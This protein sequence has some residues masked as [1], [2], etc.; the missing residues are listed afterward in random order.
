M[1]TKRIPPVIGLAG[2]GLVL[3]A[4]WIGAAIAQGRPDF[5]GTWVYNAAKSKLEVRFKL[6]SAVF[7]IDHKE[8]RFKLS[9]VFVIGGKEDKLE[10]AMDTDGRE[11]V[12]VEDGRTVHSRLY[13]DGDVLVFDVR[14]V[15]KDGREATNVVRYT[16]QDG[17]RTFVAEEK[18]RGP[19][20]QY[21][22][23]WVADRKT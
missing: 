10:W 8:P 22:N 7:S 11:Q 18:F 13:W 4:L 14:T 6:E 5:S 16:L 3:A 23:L 2:L 17:G 12:T 1:I 9:R 20:L 15:L 21:D 19:A